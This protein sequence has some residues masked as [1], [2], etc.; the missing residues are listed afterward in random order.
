MTSLLEFKQYIKR[1]INRNETYLN[2][3]WKFVLA[4]ITLALINSKLGYMEALTNFAIVMMAAL[5]CAILPPNFIIFVS[6]VFIL[7][8]LYALGVECALIALV[9]FLLMFLLYFRLSPKDTIA[10]LLTP[11]FFFMHIPYVMPL[12]AGLLGTPASVF[13]GRASV[14]IR[15]RIKM[16]RI[17]AAARTKYTKRTWEAR[18]KCR[19]SGR[20]RSHAAIVAAA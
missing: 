20:D 12:A 1:F 15:G 2:Y 13:S 11:L 9:A 10:V 7:G 3:V 4:L 8:H 18:K 6:A 16:R 19:F 5:L 17:S 14:K